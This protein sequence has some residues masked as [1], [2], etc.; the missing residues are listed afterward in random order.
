MMRMFLWWAL[1]AWPAAAAECEASSQ[2]G[3]ELRQTRLVEDH[4]Q[5]LAQAKALLD[6]HPDDLDVNLLWADVASESDPAGI[7]AHYRQRMAEASNDPRWPLISARLAGYIKREDGKKLLEELVAKHDELARGHLALAQAVAS[8]DKSRAAQELE[9]YFQQCP[10]SLEGG[11]LALRVGTPR[12]IAARA[13]AMRS[14]LSRGG[15][16]PTSWGELW[17]LEFK[18]TPAARHGA[19]R[20]LVAEDLKHLRVD[21]PDLWTLRV[22]EVGYESIGDT[23][24]KKWVG[25]Q[26]ASRFG[27]RQDSLLPVMKAWNEQHPEPS[28]KASKAERETFRALQFESAGEWV[29]RWPKLTWAWS[30]RLQ[31]TPDNLPA[32]EVKAMGEAALQADKNRLAV[33]QLWAQHQVELGRVA[34]LVAAGLRAHEKQL[35]EWRAQPERYSGQLQMQAWSDVR[36]SAW[37]ILS[38]LHAVRRD[39]AKLRELVG[40]LKTAVDE[41]AKRPPT[42]EDKWIRPGHQRVYWQARGRLAALEAHPLDAVAFLLQAERAEPDGD[43]GPTGPLAEARR[44]WRESGGSDEGWRQLET[45]KA[46][47]KPPEAVWSEVKKPLPPFSLSDLRGR[48]WSSSAFKGKTVL[49]VAFA[50]WCEPCKRELPELQKLYEQTRK[51]TDL[52]VLAL[53]VDENSGPVQPF[54]DAAQ[55]TFPVVLAYGWSESILGGSIP[56]AFVVD[57]AGTIRFERHGY[58]EGRPWVEEALATIAKAK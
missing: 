54:I 23:A 24:G 19:L 20:K 5:Q 55:Y 28:E 47:D 31:S 53:D 38:R 37:A 25:D 16:P 33:A 45:E 39:S 57:K 26:L 11:E 42:E 21:A 30:M 41:E 1:A 9:R 46:A 56:A 29:K 15:A 49:L 22:L 34:D 36:W 2:V 44:I 32:E 8:T 3:V 10:E 6:R 27:D 52:V 43:D 7:A 40:Q 18:A 12:L 35:A 14:V 13:K 48:N 4:V 50:T 58:S 17:G 51:R